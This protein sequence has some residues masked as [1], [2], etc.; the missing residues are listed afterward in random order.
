MGFFDRFRKKKT[1]M[2]IEK[3]AQEILATA[4]YNVEEFLDSNLPDITERLHLNLGDF[5][6][7]YLRTELCFACVWTAVKVLSLG[8]DSSDLTDAIEEQFIGIIHGEER[9]NSTIALVYR[10]DRYTEA[11]DDDSKENQSIFCLNILSFMFNAGVI[12]ANLKEFL[13]GVP[14]LNL[15]ILRTMSNVLTIRK[16]IK[17]TD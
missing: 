4:I 12:D 9:D 8:G 13:G 5:N 14:I 16:Q 17:I 2:N 10:F 11:W 7:D 3:A 15:F 6:N 1:H